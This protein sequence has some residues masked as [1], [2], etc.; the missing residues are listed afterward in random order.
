PAEKASIAAAPKAHFVALFVFIVLSPVVSPADSGFIFRQGYR[1][2]RAGLGPALRQRSKRCYRM[3]LR[4]PVVF[5]ALG[6]SRTRADSAQAN[7]AKCAIHALSTRCSTPR[8]TGARLPQGRAEG[9]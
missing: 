1:N 8:V 4:P 3:E 6:R 7:Q 5:M 9:D 2:E